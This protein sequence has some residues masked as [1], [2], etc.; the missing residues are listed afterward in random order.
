MEGGAERNCYFTVLESVFNMKSVNNMIHQPDERC[1]Q[2]PACCA[3]NR[4]A[5]RWL[6]AAMQQSREVPF[7]WLLKLTIKE[8][9]LKS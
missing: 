1:T 2:V 3:V 8:S 6:Y 7:T 4:R 5:G 9:L